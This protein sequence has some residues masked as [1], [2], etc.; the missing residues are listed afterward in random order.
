MLNL[1]FNNYKDNFQGTIGGSWGVMIM[2]VKPGGGCCGSMCGIGI[3]SQSVAFE[4]KTVADQG[5]A[6]GGGKNDE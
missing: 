4:K 2:K 6:A 3:G 1:R 5:K